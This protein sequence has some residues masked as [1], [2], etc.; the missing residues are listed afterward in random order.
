MV[1]WFKWWFFHPLHNRLNNAMSHDQWHL[2]FSKIH[3]NLLF[4]DLC[5]IYTQL[6][7]FS[8]NISVESEMCELG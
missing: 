6:W 8:S 1:S 4:V 7:V 2:R 3:V 5:L